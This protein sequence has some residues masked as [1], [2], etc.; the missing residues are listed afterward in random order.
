M[1]SGS[2]PETFGTGIA[3]GVR[4]RGQRGRAGQWETW[5]WSSLYRT[6]GTLGVGGP[7][8]LYSQAGFLA[9]SPI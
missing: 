7:S 9:P 4:G 3:A 5:G 8:G 2:S 6:Q 1:G